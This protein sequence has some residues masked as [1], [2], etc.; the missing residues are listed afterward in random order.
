[1][2]RGKEIDYR[3]VMPLR[4]QGYSYNKIAEI[5]SISVTSVSK[6]IKKAT[7]QRIQDTPDFIDTDAADKVC[8]QVRRVSAS[9]LD[10]RKQ[11][12]EELDV[13]TRDIDFIINADLREV[14]E[15]QAYIAASH[16]KAIKFSRNVVMSLMTELKSSMVHAD[17]LMMDLLD[18]NKTELSQEEI[19]DVRYRNLARA[20]TLS[21]ELIATLCKTIDTERKAYN[22]KDPDKVDKD[23]DSGLHEVVLHDPSKGTR[24]MSLAELESGDFDEFEDDTEAEQ[25]GAYGIKKRPPGE[26]APK[27]K[28]IG[29]NLP[30]GF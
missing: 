30:E 5:L 11:L 22:I 4:D 25:V 2:G 1:M 6:Y 10:D 21:K 12:A 27:I 18:D 23:T 19:L 3:P 29:K 7:E 13:T 16:Q 14:E 24:T 20:T 26:P 9:Y 17:A 15:V 8:H 28:F